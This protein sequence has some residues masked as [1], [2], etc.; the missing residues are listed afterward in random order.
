MKCS[1][2]VLDVIRNGIEGMHYGE[3]RIKINESGDYVEISEEHRTR[4]SKDGDASSYEGKIR[5]Y[6][7]DN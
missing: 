5:V 2:E 1:A 6:R 4:I 7:T 3:I